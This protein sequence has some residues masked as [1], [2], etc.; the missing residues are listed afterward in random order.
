MVF[1]PIFLL[2]SLMDLTMAK[3][4]GSSAMSQTNSPSIFRKSKSYS[5][6]SYIYRLYVQSNPDYRAVTVASLTLRL[7]GE[8][9]DIWWAGLCFA[10]L[11]TKALKL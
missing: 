4:T 5:V 2:I 7:S 6:S 11:V 10:G 9:D 1:L 8:Y 3:L